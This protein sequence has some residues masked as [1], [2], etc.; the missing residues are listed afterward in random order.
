[1]E[2]SKLIPKKTNRIKKIILLLSALVAINLFVFGGFYF[3]AYQ[4]KQNNQNTQIT[5]TPI[6]FKEITIPYLRSRTYQ[7]SLGKLNQATETSAYIGYLTSYDS[8]GLKVNGYL[9]IPK[10]ESPENGW[11]AIVFVHGY[12]PAQ[13]YRTLENYSSYV[14]YLAGNGFVVFKI[15][16]RGHADSE[17]EPGGGYYSAD[18]IIDTL[19]AR[20]ALQKSG[21]A[22]SKAVGLWGH[23]MAGNVIARALAAQP[24][25]PAI[26]I[27]A[28][29]VYTYSDFSEYG[30]ADNSYQ[31][32]LTQSPS[33]KKRNKM[34]EKYGQFDP[35]S[36]FWKLV[37]MTNYLSGIKGAIQINHAIDDQVVDIRYS[38]NLNNLLDK[39]LIPHELNEYPSGGHNFTGSSFN[40]AMQNTVEFFK[41]YLK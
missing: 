10:G 8:D 6:P 2:M 15:D 3:P 9:T 12:I 31:P 25:I 5:P 19:N 20:A 37:P 7:S 41:K 34:F 11:P 17:G 23:S 24:E 38:R 4:N 28:G 39:T 40:E 30:I 26:V 16:L 35:N 27:W 36:S 22:N 21:F 32:P 13:N 14:D 33:R 29:A 1:M 18:Y